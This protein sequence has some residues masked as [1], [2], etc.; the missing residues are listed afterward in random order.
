MILKYFYSHDDR[1]LSVAGS[2]RTNETDRRRDSSKI[3]HGAKLPHENVVMKRD[4][5]VQSYSCTPCVSAA[6][7][8]RRCQ[9]TAGRE[10]QL[11]GDDFNEANFAFGPVSDPRRAPF[12]HDDL[13]EPAEGAGDGS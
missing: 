11:T 2:H 1:F 13:P 8:Q 10:R 12:D 5:C 7:V 3:H 6:S 4:G 9:F